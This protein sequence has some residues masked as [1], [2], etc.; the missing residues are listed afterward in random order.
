MYRHYGTWILVIAIALL[1][2]PALA[3]DE[4]IPATS[5]DIEAF[6]RALTRTRQRESAEEQAPSATQARK[7]TS[8]EIQG[9]EPAA[10][11]AGDGAG[12]T[13]R[14]RTRTRAEKQRSLAVAEEAQKMK[15]AQAQ[16]KAQQRT[17]E[18]LEAQ[19]EEGQ[20]TWERA[21]TMREY[22]GGAGREQGPGAPPESS[23]GGNQ[24]GASSG[25]GQ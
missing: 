1:A 13:E 20:G 22:S 24:G 11:P 10:G 21:R 17:R 18:R 7:R 9:E 8:A 25:S 14:V 12:M 6:D 3:S 16:E 19:V 2:L 15:H 5:E 23:E 4:V